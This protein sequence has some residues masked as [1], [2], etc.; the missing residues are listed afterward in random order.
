M[1]NIAEKY[2]YNL[3]NQKGFTLLEILAVIVIIGILASTTIHRFGLLSD[4]ASLRLLAAG[5]RE[6]NIRETLVWT[7]YKISDEG[8]PGDNVI[9]A[10][11]ETALGTGYY[12]NPAVNQNGGSLHLGSQSIDLVRIFSTNGSAGVWR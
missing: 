8:W 9:Y 5:K 3:Q 7:Q 11:V 2:E 4:T 10:A 6:L 12:W 1:G